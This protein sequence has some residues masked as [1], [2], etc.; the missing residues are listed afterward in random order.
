VSKRLVIQSFLPFFL[1]SI[2][3]PCSTSS[4]RHPLHFPV[5][6]TNDNIYIDISFSLVYFSWL[7]LSIC[8]EDIH[9][10]L[11]SVCPS[12]FDQKEGHDVVTFLCP[13]LLEPKKRCCLVTELDL[14][15]LSPIR[16]SLHLHVPNIPMGAQLCKFVMF[17]LRWRIYRT[18]SSSSHRSACSC[19]DSI[20]QGKDGGFFLS[21][22][23]DEDV[24]PAFTTHNKRV[25][26]FVYGKNTGIVPITNK[27]NACSCAYI[28]L[29]SEDHINP[30]VS[31]VYRAI[32]S[33]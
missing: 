19:V 22:G 27:Y 29:L 31:Y 6:K 32:W 2:L 23:R 5:D 3:P 13:W 24:L 4:H 26:T 15:L 20:L 10:E 28:V 7:C 8:C 14:F 21:R 16:F 30:K 17:F 11:A 33:R 18:C 25:R 12:L 9:M 1:P